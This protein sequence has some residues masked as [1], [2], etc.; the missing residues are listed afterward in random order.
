MS[1]VLYLPLPCELLAGPWLLRLLFLGMLLLSWTSYRRTYPQGWGK[2]LLLK[3]PRSWRLKPRTPEAYEGCQ[4]GLKVQIFRPRT[5]V[6]PYRET[7]SACGRRK[8]LNTAGYA[9]PNLACA[10]FAVT[11]EG[12]HAVVGNGKRGQ[13]QDIQSWKCQ[14]CQKKFTSRLH[15]PLY[16]LKTD[17]EKVVLV[18]ML[19]ANGCDVSVLV[20]CTPHA[21]AT[22]TRWLEKMGGA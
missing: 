19:L 7:K 13:R 8:T 5:D 20:R 6:V 15:T 4:K 14:A 10:Y 9:C 18:L 12:L 16:R 2:T 17:P 3:S 11:D 1:I 21:E 22:V